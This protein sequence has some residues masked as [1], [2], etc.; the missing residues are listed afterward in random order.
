MFRGLEKHI[1]KIH[2]GIRP[3]ICDKCGVSYGD[4]SELKIHMT[5]HA[6]NKPFACSYCDYSTFQKCNLKC[7]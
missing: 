4:E 5:R 2:L 3:Y 1:S 7:K 6:E